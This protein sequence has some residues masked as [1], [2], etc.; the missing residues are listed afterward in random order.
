MEAFG[1]PSISKQLPVKQKKPGFS[2]EL[3]GNRTQTDPVYN[4]KSK[5]TMIT[6]QTDELSGVALAR[7]SIY[8]IIVNINIGFS[9]Y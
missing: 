9:D 8:K 7:E 2:S 6:N 5:I 3:K 4:S 1:R